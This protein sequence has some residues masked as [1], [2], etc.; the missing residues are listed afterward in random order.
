MQRRRIV[1]VLS[2]DHSGSTWVGYVLGSHPASAFLGE[3]ERAWRKEASVPCT[4]CAAKGLDECE[5]LHGAADVPVDQAFAWAFARTG[6]QV[7]VDNSKMIDWAARF[8]GADGGDAVRLIHV[9]KD[10]RNWLCSKRRRAAQPT[11][12]MIRLWHAT[13]AQFQAF[14]LSAG[15]PSMTVFYDELAADPLGG[16]CRL[17]AFCGLTFDESALSYWNFPHHG[18]AANGA[19]S[20]I[21]ADARL[22]PPPP[23]FATGDDGFY[24]AH[25]RQLFADLR[26]KRALGAEEI[27]A[28]AADRDVADL[29]ADFGRRLTPDGLAR[30]GPLAGVR[31]QAR[32]LRQRV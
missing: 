17:F 5:V 29:L 23:H 16:F 21:L 26:W 3:Y 10:P 20:A 13:N 7:L 12:D 31:R 27:A 22:G 19:S 30:L 8:I 14:T 18:F 11:A 2:S 4:L 15:C 9:V 32:R 1:F 25:D 6:R 24:A 28:I